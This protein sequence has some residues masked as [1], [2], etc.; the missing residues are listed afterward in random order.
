MRA[1]AAG[2]KYMRMTLRTSAVVVNVSRQRV[3][4]EHAVIADRALTR[5]RGLLGRPDL[6][7]GE[8]LLLEP[9][10]AIHTAFMRFPIDVVFLDAYLRVIKVV[11]PLPPWRSA[12]ARGGRAVLELPAGEAGR[13]DVKLGDRLDVQE[14]AGTSSLTVPS[15]PAA[16]DLPADTRC[17]L[18]VSSDRRFRAM[19][20]AL[21][22]QRGWAVT[23]G[24][25]RQD[26]SRLLSRSRPE[27]VLVD[28]TPSLTDAARIA[29]EVNRATGPRGIVLVS[30]AADVEF[31]ALPIYPK[32]GSFE[33]LYKAV[34]GARAERA[35]MVDGA[36]LQHEGVADA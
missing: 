15:R 13:R 7:V 32:W 18:L 24:D 26:I 4:C 34:E 20:A 17:M 36:G 27:V 16:V 6:P 25:L 8:G 35:A 28:A 12:L 19:A 22:A 29:A 2:A 30:S 3:V 31:S 14:Y 10:P 33:L 9:A 1:S 5:M 23:A 21:F 11:S